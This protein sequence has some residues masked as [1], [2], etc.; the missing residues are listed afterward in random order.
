MKS[1]PVNL[2]YNV[3]IKVRYH[4]DSFCM[5]GNQFPHNST[6][7]NEIDA[8]YD[9]VNKR[10]TNILEVYKLLAQDIVYI[11]IS[12]RK[13]DVKLLSD[14]RLDKS[15]VVID[16]MT[17]RDID[18]ISS[19]SNIPVSTNESSLGTPLKVTFVDNLITS[20]SVTRVG[21]SFN[22]LDKIKAQSKLLPN[23]HKDKITTFDSS[24]KFYLTNI[25]MKYYVLAIKY[26]DS[27]KVI[28]ISY[29]LNGVVDK[30]VTDTLLSCNTV[31][32]VHGNTEFLIDNGNVVY[33]K[34]DLMLRPVGKP[35]VTY[36]PG[37]NPNI[38][39]IDL[40]T[41]KDIDDK[42]KVY[43][44]GFM[45]NLVD[46]PTIYYLKNDLTSHDLIINLVNETFL[47]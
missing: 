42:V 35:K 36:M 4:K 16:N 2:S 21:E 40:E 44:A 18:T 14:F 22:L 5:A 19:T 46:R 45:T 30:S 9:V 24:F 28:K 31:S 7:T 32:R 11:Q 38:G 6:S 12:F 10:I 34:K 29:F 1:I 41:F 17:K 27:N 15:D 47:F 43:A 33:S 23:N 26:V 8:L 13:L 39:V 25:N 20:I 37:E 3:F